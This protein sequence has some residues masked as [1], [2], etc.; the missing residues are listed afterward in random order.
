MDAAISLNERAA[1]LHAN[2]QA[3][4]AGEV[5]HRA[6]HLANAREW[7]RRHRAVT[8]ADI[9]NGVQPAAIYASFLSE[10]KMGNLDPDTILP[11]ILQ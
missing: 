1:R 4:D 2:A 11:A 10:C 8:P 7:L 3:G 9:A 6:R 5:D